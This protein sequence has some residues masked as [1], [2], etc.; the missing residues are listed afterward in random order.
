[1]TGQYHRDPFYISAEVSHTTGIYEATVE[2][3]KEGDPEP[4]V[5][6]RQVYTANT[7]FGTGSDATIKRTLETFFIEPGNYYTHTD[8]EENTVIPPT[9]YN[10]VDGTYNFTVKTTSVQTSYATQ[11]LTIYIDTTPP[12]INITRVQPNVLEYSPAG[13]P[14]EFTVNGFIAADMSSYDANNIGVVAPSPLA[15]DAAC[16]EIKCLI[17]DTYDPHA[18]AKDLYNDSAAQYFDNP[19]APVY[20]RPG[21]TSS[22]IIDTTALVSGADYYAGKDQYLHFIAKDKAGNYSFSAVR[23]KVDQST[24][25]PVINIPGFDFLQRSEADIKAADAPNKLDTDRILSGTIVDDDKV[26]SAAPGSDIKL[27]IYQ[28][29][30]ASPKET[31]VVTSGDL[32]VLNE[33]KTVSFRVGLPGADQLPDG[34]YSLEMEARDDAVAKNKLKP[35]AS[36]ADLLPATVSAT[37]SDKQE[38]KRRIYF[39]LDTAPPAITETAIGPTEVEP[40]LTAGY[41]SLAGTVF[42]VNGLRSLKIIQTEEGFAG[43]NTV[44]DLSCNAED[45]KPWALPDLPR[46]GTSDAPDLRAGTFA[47]E[48]IA[49]DIA[50]RPAKLTRTVVVDTVK[51]GLTIEYPA[52]NSWVDGTFAVLKGREEDNYRAGPVFYAIEAASS[53]GAPAPNIFGGKTTPG[54]YRDD[55]VHHWTELGVVGADWSDN[56]RLRTEDGGIGEGIFFLYAAAFD[57]AGNQTANAASV[58]TFGVDQA[59]PDLGKVKFAGVSD[60]DP[61]AWHV[62]GRFSLEGAITDHNGLAGITLTEQRDSDSP[63]TLALS[64]MQRGGS[65]GAAS[66]ALN[67]PGLPWNDSAGPVSTPLSGAYTYTLTVPDTTGRAD[68]IALRTFT[69]VYDVDGPALTIIDPLANADVSGVSVYIS[70]TA[71]DA[72]TTDG[73]EVWYLIDPNPAPPLRARYAG[74]CVGRRVDP[75]RRN[76][77]VH[78]R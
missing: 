69:I 73:T 12:E 38:L 29:S 43:S 47:Y 26:L 66:W 14:N 6:A 18:A 11:T 71:P 21:S 50:R 39:V 68:R 36:L 24:D 51:P 32:T 57:A 13:A 74:G 65:I 46:A 72:Y 67:V 52:P 61:V 30:D 7:P 48:I 64:D 37:D 9:N 23:L 75:G 16:R 35:L 27:R 4:T 41:F 15:P 44:L 22:L 56:I 70:G 19:L 33:G 3:Q 60:T 1:L 45:T 25:L 77:L 17:L 49:E 40:R 28:G 8:V 5:L 59:A 78:K 2:V 58:P 76:I 54:D 62:N 10:F 42:D 34:I 31:V 53:M 63:I 20:K 55:G